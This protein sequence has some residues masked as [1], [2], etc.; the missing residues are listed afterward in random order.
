[1]IPFA[2]AH[3]FPGLGFFVLAMGYSMRTTV[4]LAT[5]GRIIVQKKKKESSLWMP[6]A[7]L[8]HPCADSYIK[9]AYNIF[10]LVFQL[11]VEMVMYNTSIEGFD[12]EH[13][14]THNV[15]FWYKTGFFNVQYDLWELIY[16][17]RPHLVMYFGF[18]FGA[19]IELLMY[20]GEPMPKNSDK[21]MMAM[22]FL[23]ETFVFSNHMHGR[24]HLDAQLHVFLAYAV[25]G[26]YKHFSVSFS[27]KFLLLTCFS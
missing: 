4:Q 3:F 25:Y 14:R 24:E 9:L 7:S 19:F 27:A 8:R 21:A 11:W 10:A 18:A 1:M 12:E 17:N 15:T 26:I 5:H 23:L 20:Y 22:A 13:V 6:C 2:L 16:R